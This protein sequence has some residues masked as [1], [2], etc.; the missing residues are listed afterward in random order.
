[1]SPL[2]LVCVPCMGPVYP[3]YILKINHDK[4]YAVKMYMTYLCN[5]FTETKK[6]NYS[7]PTT[8]VWSVEKKVSAVYLQFVYLFNN[9]AYFQNFTIRI[10]I[11]G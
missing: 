10:T 8:P 3:L 5:L 6:Y 4:G 1:M 9:N 11:S 7:L 2:Y